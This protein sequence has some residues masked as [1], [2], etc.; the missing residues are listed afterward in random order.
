MEDDEFDSEEEARKYDG[1]AIECA[2]DETLFVDPRLGGSWRC[3]KRIGP[4]PMWCPGK[5]NTE[6]GCDDGP[7]ACPIGECEC[8]GQLRVAHDCK[9][10]K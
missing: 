6:C 7:E 1:C 10:A 2:E 8:D 5:F 4:M 3:N 9:T